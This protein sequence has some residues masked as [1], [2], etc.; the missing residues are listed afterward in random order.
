M[1]LSKEQR[2][3]IVSKYQLSKGDTGSSQVQVAL[4]TA[5]LDYLNDHFKNN[6]NDNHSRRGLMKMVSQRKRL[7]SYLKSTDEGAYKKLIS[8][9]GLRK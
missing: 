3:E 4:L 6:K 1:P 8:D 7:L 2:E 9:L 5:R